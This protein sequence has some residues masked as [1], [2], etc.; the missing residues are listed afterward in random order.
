MRISADSNA[1]L[2][3]TLIGSIMTAYVPR[4]YNISTSM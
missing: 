2:Y 1:L 3:G 4:S